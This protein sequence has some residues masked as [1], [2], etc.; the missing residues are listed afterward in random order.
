MENH[1]KEKLSELA[2]TETMT[3]IKAVSSQQEYDELFLLLSKTLF[4]INHSTAILTD[5][6]NGAFEFI[7]IE[8]YKDEI[9][10]IVASWVNNLLI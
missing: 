8:N 2:V 1:F 4:K 3:K 10:E 9:S 7:S 5:L 6:K